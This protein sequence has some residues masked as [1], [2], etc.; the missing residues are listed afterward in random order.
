VIIPLPTSRQADVPDDVIQLAP[1][2]RVRVL[3]APFHG[4]VGIVR[5][6]PLKA[7]DFPSGLL[8]RSAAIEIEG[9][10]NRLIPLANLEVIQ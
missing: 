2:V 7:A 10:G 8:A 3:R 6:L 9:L 4:A 1:G 5:D